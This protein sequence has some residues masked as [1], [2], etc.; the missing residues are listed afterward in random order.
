MFKRILIASDGS[1][2]ALKAAQAAGEIAQKF[3]ASLLLLSVFNPP[4]TVAPFAGGLQPPIDPELIAR[5][6]EETQDAIERQTGSVL[7]KLGVAYEARREVGHPAERIIGVAGRENVDL[8]VMG[9]RGLSGLQSFLLGSISDRVL[10]H[11][12]CPVLIVK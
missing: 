2:Y 11:A 1:D 9:S 10:H 6:G 4:P 5:Y 8:I 12:H 7:E 3:G